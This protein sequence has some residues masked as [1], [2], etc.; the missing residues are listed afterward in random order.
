MAKAHDGSDFKHRQR[1]LPQYK[2]MAQVKRNLKFVMIL[3]LLVGFLMALKLTPTILD[4]LNIF[5]QPIE[6][7]Y[8]PMAK[9][10]EWVWF[11]SV[12]ITMLAFKAIRTN[13]TLQMKVFMFAVVTTCI[14]PLIYCVYLHSADFRTYVI[15]RDSKNTSEVWRGYPV[16]LFWCIFTVVAIQIHGFELY[17]SWELLRSTGGHRA[18]NK[19]K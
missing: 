11:S 1:I 16:A 12:M 19:N 10:W 8:I 2:M 7:L 5:W 3:H 9:S 4:M 17:F 6:E 14:L 15:T 13:N 18:V